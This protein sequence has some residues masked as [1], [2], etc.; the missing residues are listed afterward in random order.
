MNQDVKLSIVIVSFNTKALVVQCLKHLLTSQFPNNWEVIV[1]DNASTDGTVN[2]VE[3]GK[4][5]VESEKLKIIKNKTNVGFSVANNQGM[6]LGNGEYILLLNSDTMASPQ[7]VQTVLTYLEKHEEAGV[8]TCKLVLSDGR[9]DPASHRGFPTPWAAFTYFAGL[10]K[11]FPKSQLFS[12]YH[13]WYKDLTRTHEIDS[14]S[15]A[16]FMVRRRVTNEVGLLDESYFM[17]GEDL[18]WAYRIKMAGW[19][20]VFIPDA[21]V[22]HLKKQSG[23]ASGDEVKQREAKKHFYETMLQFYNKHYRGEYNSLIT[24]FVTMTIR[25]RLMSL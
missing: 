1:V 17:Y 21:E 22:T 19:K 14:P 3:S 23:W 8:A 5:K 4:W 6:K 15:G 7:A 13:Q 24:A 10:E 12:Q 18:D 20:I 11:L 16:F 9:I 2:E 25:L